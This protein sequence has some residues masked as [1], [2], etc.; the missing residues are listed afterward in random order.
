MDHE[1][2]T[3]AL[4]LRDYSDRRVDATPLHCLGDRYL[5][6]GKAVQAGE[7][8]ELLLRCVD[9]VGSPVPV[10]HVRFCRQPVKILADQFARRIVQLKLQEIGR[11]QTIRVGE[12]ERFGAAVR[13]V[14]L[15]A[16]RSSVASREAFSLASMS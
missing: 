5:R 16:P 8:G 10:E 3:G 9:G 11:R 14:L 7:V 4:V 15:S 2:H 13:L 6:L 1:C 12:I